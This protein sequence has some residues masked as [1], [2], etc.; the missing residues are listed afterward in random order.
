MRTIIIGLII[1]LSYFLL[2]SIIKK[3]KI[4]NKKDKNIMKYCDYCKSY[5][6]EDEP[7]INKDANHKNL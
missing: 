1:V 4:A 3:N 6:T 2:K 7:C 5:V